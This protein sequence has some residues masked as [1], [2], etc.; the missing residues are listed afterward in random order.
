MKFPSIPYFNE[1]D[2]SQFI[3]REVIMAEKLDGLNVCL[4]NGKAYTRDNAGVP[5]NT[6]YMAMV[7]KYHAWKTAGDTG[8]FYYGEDLFAEHACVYDPIPE[9]ETF[10]VFMIMAEDGRVLSWDETIERCLNVG[11]IPVPVIAKSIFNDEKGAVNALREFEDEGVSLLGG[12]REGSVMRFADSFHIADI[13]EKVCKSVRRGHVQPNAD[14]W[15]K[16]WQPR[17]MYRL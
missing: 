6:P 5:H 1:T 11:L 2:L 14:H 10:Y 16:N 8:Y 12:E 17:Q 15:R 7:K 13:A 9:S 3:S 4:H